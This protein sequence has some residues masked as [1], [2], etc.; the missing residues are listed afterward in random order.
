MKSRRTTVICPTHEHGQKLWGSEER[1]QAVARREYAK[2]RRVLWVLALW[3][4]IGSF[5]GQPTLCRG[6]YHYEP[7]SDSW[8][9]PNRFVRFKIT[10]VGDVR[11]DDLHMYIT[12]Q[13]TGD[14]GM[15]PY[16]GN[17]QWEKVIKTDA[18][19][20]EVSV[21]IAGPRAVPPTSPY[22]QTE[23]PYI[24][25][26]D[27]DP[28]EYRIEWYVATYTYH[29][30]RRI[31]AVP[32]DRSIYG[33]K[34]PFYTAWMILEGE[35]A[36]ISNKNRPPVAYDTQ[37][38]TPVGTPTDITLAAMDPDADSLTF[39]ILS[40]PAHGALSA[41]SSLPAPT[42]TYTPDA[43]YVGD[44]GFTFRVYDGK[45][46]SQP[47]T[48]TIHVQATPLAPRG[49]ISFSGDLAFFGAINV[50]QLYGYVEVKHSGG[51]TRVYLSE[52][53][54]GSRIFSGEAKLPDSQGQDCEAVL[55]VDVGNLTLTGHVLL[56]PGWLN[57][58]QGASVE[59]YM[60]LYTSWQFPTEWEYPL[61]E[62][63]LRWNT[64]L[65]SQ[66]GTV[67]SAVLQG[68][69]VSAV[70]APG[71]G[72]LPLPDQGWPWPT[73]SAQDGEEKSEPEAETGLWWSPATTI[74]PSTGVMQVR[75]C[76][77]LEAGAL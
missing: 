56:T 39:G 69:T 34:A 7:V 13:S 50:E 58:D 8:V 65:Y 1:L 11:G 41:S 66:P 55:S 73:C 36:R 24:Y 16:V 43:G 17:G 30:A 6:E 25:I 33:P 18:Y 54:S 9:G 75:V 70:D 77:R 61:A 29:V 44:D 26:G 12:E 35:G 40:Q 28:G 32:E 42:M 21:T 10:N 53:S 46:W 15:L 37:V 3:F 23:Y 63:V 51:L 71:G 67:I 68:G 31:P 57:I 45:L 48:V 60:I 52:T 19:D 14:W 22:G 27:L 49:S 20:L 47:A 5:P 2:G 38:T 59:A 4:V 72:Y 74:V 62:M 64:S 76:Y